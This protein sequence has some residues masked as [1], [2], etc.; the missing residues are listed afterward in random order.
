MNF[1]FFR[2]KQDEDLD[3]EIQSH[4]R[5]AAEDR[6]DRGETPEQAELSARRELGNQGLI[7]EAT[8]NMW[9]WTWLER[10]LQDLRFS[11]RMLGKNPGS[12]FVSVF[13]LALGVGASTAIFSVVYG[14]LLRPL[15]FDKPEQIV[16]VWE[17][18]DQG[19]RMAVADPN[20][21]DLRAQNHTFQSLV[22]Y[23]SGLESVSGG[24]EPRRITVASVSQDFFSVMAVHAVRGREF[25]ADEQHPG[26]MPAALVSYSFWQQYLNGANDLS[27]LKL[28]VE[29]KATSV[30]G[31][32]PPGFHFPD[33]ADLWVAS[34][35]NGETPSRTAHNVNVLGRLRE[36]M[37]VEQGQSDL[38]A[39]ARRLKREYGQ[40]I[41]MQSAAVVP[42][43][44]ALTG[45]VRPALLVLLGAV[46][47]L[48]L[49]ACAN[50]MNLLLAQA[51]AREGE[52][53]V[54]SALG[55]SRW[56]LVRQFLAESLLLSLLGGA[57]G[58]IAAYWGLRALLRIVPPNTPRVA[59]IA[60]NLPVLFFALGLSILLAAA[61]GI[62]TALR[63]TSGD[64][65]ATLAERGRAQSNARSTQSLGRAI[66]AGQLAM[67]LLLLAGAGLEAR[68]LLRVLSVDPGFRTEQV[69]TMDIVLPAARGP[70]RAPRVEFLTTLLE[71]MRSLPGVTQAGLTNSLPI[72]GGSASN[73]T[74]VELSYGQLSPRTKE[75]IE[76]A[77]HTDVEQLDPK[78]M[79]ELIRFLED[80][81]HDRQPS[82][83]AFYAMVSDD[84]FQT[85]GIPLRRGRFFD[86]GDSA[87]APHAAIISESV[88]RQKWPGLNPLGRT[89][90]FG[91]IDGDL[92]LLTVVGVVGDVKEESLESPPEPIIYVNYRQRPQSAQPVSIVMRTA[93][94]PAATLAAA[95]KVL[96]QLDPTVPPRLETFTEVFAASVDGRRFNL[97]LLG[98]FAATALVLAAAGI[99]GV[100]AYSVTRRTREIGVRIALGAS[101]ST[102]LRLVFGQSMRT[103][104]VGIGVGTIASF[105]F[106]RLMRSFLFEIS[107]YDPLT[108][109]L[110][111]FLLLAVAGLASFL[112]ARRATRV[113]PN[114]ALRHE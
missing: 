91:N 102:V 47:F 2:G 56:R 39:I 101:S 27:A 46:G 38:D 13:T 73:G 8:R 75:L 114:L 85:L 21:D 77:A 53:A 32:L 37:L 92:R 88:A 35:T 55:A 72:A 16:R 58:V 78:T 84:Y 7:K 17:V 6:M 23:E 49:V 25:I 59:D 99:Y 10:L 54:R 70:A 113:D 41:D 45:E 90:E 14:V 43:K 44:A 97:I 4:L 66:V 34:E 81:F 108:F 89:I 93:A 52:L 48:L 22:R 64:V 103:A 11:W 51:S 109:V 28:V 18:N 50:V 69:V 31:V 26:A 71:R 80:L 36:G 12:T 96:A 94:D 19:R 20:F 29:N 33:N 9:G 98:V 111:A 110:V 107:P 87:D 1:R 112:P 76:R 104:L 3:E 74:F 5:M 105:L 42:L 100:M 95:R 106:A 83:Y 63:A 82:G 57:L 79:Q 15:P 86:G 24:S 68:S 61:L 30:I 62:F 60:I 67:T 65:Q 40:D